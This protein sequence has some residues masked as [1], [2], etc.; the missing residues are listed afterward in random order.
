MYMKISAVTS[1]PWHLFR[2]FMKAT[3]SELM[4]WWKKTKIFIIRIHQNDMTQLNLFVATNTLWSVCQCFTYLHINIFAYIYIYPSYGKMRWD[5][6]KCVSFK[7]W[8]NTKDWHESRWM[9]D[10]KGEKESE[11]EK[12]ANAT[13]TNDN[14]VRR[15]DSFYC[16]VTEMPE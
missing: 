5:S 13:Y 15:S 14:W 1:P 6:L 3:L 4:R 2:Y 7:N 8:T 12:E 11:K 10:E 9:A 16:S